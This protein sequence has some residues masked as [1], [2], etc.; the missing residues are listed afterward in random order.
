MAA[1][2]TMQEMKDLHNEKRDH[3]LSKNDYQGTMFYRGAD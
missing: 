3:P 2:Y 1:T